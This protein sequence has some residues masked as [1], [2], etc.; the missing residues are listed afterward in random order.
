MT[1]PGLWHRW[2]RRRRAR[3]LRRFRIP[4]ARWRRVERQALTRYGLNVR[5]RTRLHEL[6]SLF[7][8]TK[9]IVGADGLQVNEVM[10]GVIAAQACLLILNLDLSDYDGVHEIIV[11]PGSF[12]V[13]HEVVDESGVVHVEPR[14]LTGEAWGEGPL[15]LG[16]ADARP[17]V[18]GSGTG[19]NVILHE[20][21]HK[22]DMNNGVANG[23]PP[24]HAGMDRRAWTA[25]FSAAFERLQTRLRHHHKTVLDPY[26]AE[27][28]AEFFAV[29]TEAFFETPRALKRAC[30]EV[31]DQLR[32]YY[33]QD[34]LARSELHGR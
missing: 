30:P 11:Y 17:D 31:Y 6:A 29:A 19:H 23:M 1:M 33:R 16:W 3:R 13:A 14:A 18:Q 2:Q 8:R 28:P 27:N 34:P 24:L 5:E 10:R 7:L 12:M 26:A 20:F 9:T 22:L 21:A 4:A 15:I 25:A 32:R